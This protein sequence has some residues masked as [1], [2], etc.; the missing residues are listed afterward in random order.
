MA[1]AASPT[2]HLNITNST[3]SKYDEPVAV[4]VGAARQK[5]VA[6]NLAE[7]EGVDIKI[8]DCHLSRTHGHGYVEKTR[9]SGVGKGG[10]RGVER[11]VGCS[12]ENGEKRRGW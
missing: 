11:E 3:S 4:S 9:G 1:A 12:R 6:K 10:R 7:R 5:G 2:F 8:D